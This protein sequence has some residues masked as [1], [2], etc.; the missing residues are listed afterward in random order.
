MF[1]KIV[2]KY[3]ESQCTKCLLEN[4]DEGDPQCF[5]RI[6]R[7]A[8]R[9]EYFKEHYRRNREKKIAAATERNQQNHAE[10]L[11][12]QANYRKLTRPSQQKLN[13]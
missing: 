2:P 9:S 13:V 3:D 8:E 12:Y 5:F 4:C 10:Y 6:W 7:I 11:A 1:Y